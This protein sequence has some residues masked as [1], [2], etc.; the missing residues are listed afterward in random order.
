MKNAAVIGYKDISEKREEDDLGRYS[1]GLKSATRSF[2]DDVVISSKPYDSRCNS[3]EIDYFHI[4]ESKKW[5]AFILNDFELEKEIGNHGTLVCCRNL[6]FADG[7]SST[8][9]WSAWKNPSA[10]YSVNS[11]YQATYVYQFK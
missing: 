10:M 2:C 7:A 11:Y 1:T 3:I 9:S 5:E 8:Q 6:H 4:T